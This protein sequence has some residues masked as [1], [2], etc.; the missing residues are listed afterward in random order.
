[1]LW[2]KKAVGQAGEWLIRPEGKTL[3]LV[4][5]VWA[6]ETIG[7]WPGGFDVFDGGLVLKRAR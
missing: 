7:V 6:F 3:T 5:G 4:Q 2:P 1:M